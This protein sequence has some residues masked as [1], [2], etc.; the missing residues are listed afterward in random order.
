MVFSMAALTS[1]NRSDAWWASLLTHTSFTQ[2][3]SLSVSDVP[4]TYRSHPAAR[5]PSCPLTN[6]ATTSSR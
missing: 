6:V 5:S 3:R 2:T 1:G 4:T